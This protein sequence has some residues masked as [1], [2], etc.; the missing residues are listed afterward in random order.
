MAV[1]EPDLTDDLSIG[2]R[3]RTMSMK[4]AEESVASAPGW[5]ARASPSK[6]ATKN[7]RPPITGDV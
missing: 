5:V 1:A 7:C 4:R 2:R 6:S 3:A